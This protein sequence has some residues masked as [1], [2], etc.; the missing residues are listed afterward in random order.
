MN[1]KRACPNGRKRFKYVQDSKVFK[2]S[3]HTYKMKHNLLHQILE[4]LSF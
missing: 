3:N 4:D 2:S 1:K